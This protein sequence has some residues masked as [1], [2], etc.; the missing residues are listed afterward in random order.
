[1]DVVGVLFID[2]SYLPRRFELRIDLLDVSVGLLLSLYALQPTGGKN[3]RITVL[4]KCT[5][6]RD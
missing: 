6:S 1:M 2:V 4:E 5:R 3:K